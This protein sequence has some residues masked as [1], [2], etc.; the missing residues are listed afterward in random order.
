MGLCTLRIVNMLVE[1]EYKTRQRI[2]SYIYDIR[3][4]TL[5][6]LKN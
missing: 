4:D 1:L 2:K 3:Y 5:F 6:A